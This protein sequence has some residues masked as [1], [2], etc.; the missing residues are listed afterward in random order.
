M[1][2][3]TLLVHLS[4][5]PDHLARLDTA[6]EFA[7]GFGAHLVA[8]YVTTPVGMPAAIVGRGASSAYIAEATAIAEEKAAALAAEFGDHCRRYGIAGEWRTESGDHLDI[9]KSHAL[10]ADLAIVGRQ[11]P[12]TIEDHVRLHMPEQLPLFTG[13]PVL[14][15]P[16][17]D[18]VWALPRCALVGWKESVPSQRA[19]QAALPLLQGARE[20]YLL[21]CDEKDRRTAIAQAAI[22]YLARHGLKLEADNEAGGDAMAGEVLVQRAA[23]RGADLI[24]MGAWGHSR[25][26]E[27]VLGGATRYVLQHA[28][29]PLLMAH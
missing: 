23:D 14:V 4:N 16:P 13:C 15:L 21:T 18:K 9:L 6:L 25:L 12:E 22:T 1:T 7:R 29:I 26:R 3:K 17:G 5:A 27:L 24:V 10:Y 11:A 8:L 20:I 2:Y 19:V 28:S